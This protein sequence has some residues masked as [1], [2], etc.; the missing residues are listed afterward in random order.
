[1]KKLTAIV[2]GLGSRGCIYSNAMK[3]LEDKF[4]VVAL[5]DPLKTHLNTVKGWHNIPDENCYDSWEDILNQPKMADFAV[6][7]TQDNMHLAPA[8]KAIEKGY[9]LLLEKPVSQT[10]EEC[11]A[12][13]NAAEAK[14]VKVLVCHVL[15]Y[16]DFYGRIKKLVLDDTIG[17]IMSII[18]VEGVGNIHQS[19]SFVRGNWHDTTKCTPMILA[20]CSHDLDIIQWLMDKPCKKVQSFGDLT[21]F[22]P[23][24]APEGA[25]KR[26]IDGGCPA[27]ATC[28]YSAKRVYVDD[29]SPDNW[30]REVAAGKFCIDGGP[31]DE[32]VI[33]KLK[34]TNYGLC[35]YQAGNNAVDHQVVNLEFE[36]GATAS[37]T[38]NAF[39]KG[40]RYIRIFGTKGELYANMRDTEITV[41]TFADRQY[42]TVNVKA[43]E[44]TIVGG[45]GG[46]DTGILNE[47]YDY[48]SDN[49][50]GYKAANISTS[51]K[52]HLLAFAA[53][54]SRLGDTVVDMDKFVESFGMVNKY[55][56]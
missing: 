53:E 5:A 27:E 52:N 43:T 34:T 54:K 35:V 4:Q 48:F 42:H 40:G 18:Q 36:G 30:Y 55:T 37:L 24:N 20:K 44:E 39:N 10:P 12:I 22:R 8:L 11:T 31:T 51:V 25:P 23:E 45:H 46:G 14:G 15:R 17:E 2:I 26:C 29:H 41:Y 38:M 33:E 13:A 21:H 1:M 7:C 50:E 56:K 9:N 6:I 28:P 32:E 16:T 49:Y 3:K 47:L 19:H